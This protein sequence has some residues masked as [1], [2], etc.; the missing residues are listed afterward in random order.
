MS[1]TGHGAHKSSLDLMPGIN[2]LIME[3]VVTNATVD[4]P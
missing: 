1:K 3:A 4:D 2:G